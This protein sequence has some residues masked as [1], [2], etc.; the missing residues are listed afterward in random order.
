[1]ALNPSIDQLINKEYA[2]QQETLTLIPSENYVSAAV[3][4]AQASCFTNKYAEGYPGK[5]YYGGTKF[6]D[7]LELLCQEQAKKVFQTDYFVNVQPYSGSPA[8]VAVYFAP[9]QPGDTIMGLNLAAGGH[10][11]HGH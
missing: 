4:Q 7:E 3:Q 10:L 5:R 11:T 9:L 6:C 1:M 8:N 2:R